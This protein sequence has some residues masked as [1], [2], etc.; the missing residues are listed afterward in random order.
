LE[1][2]TLGKG[3]T[4]H[5]IANSCFSKIAQEKRDIRR[6]PARTEEKGEGPKKLAAH[7]DC[8]GGN[9]I[10]AIPFTSSRSG[11]RTVLQGGEKRTK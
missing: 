3:E 4:E 5:K 7:L 1:R 11:R 2:T 8:E 9:F 10:G 6:G